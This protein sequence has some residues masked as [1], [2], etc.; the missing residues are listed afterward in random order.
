MVK[1][2][3]WWSLEYS[4]L[5]NFKSE[6]LKR[7][8]WWVLAWWAPRCFMLSVEEEAS[9]RLLPLAW[10]SEWLENCAFNSLNAL[11]MFV[12]LILNSFVIMTLLWFVACA[13]FHVSSFSTA[14]RLCVLNKK[15]NLVFFYRGRFFFPFVIS[16]VIN[17]AKTSFI[18]LLNYFMMGS[19]IFWLNEK[20]RQGK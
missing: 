2:S 17:T 14:F 10:L 19:I 3:G 9:R 16:S 11:S 12:L 13:P 20:Q 7:D 8:D 1:I 5:S 6:L 15:K 4:D 18:T